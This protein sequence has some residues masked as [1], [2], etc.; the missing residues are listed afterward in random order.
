[1][2]CEQSLPA[3]LPFIQETWPASASF[4][5]PFPFILEE[6][7]AATAAS[8]CFLPT[9]YL[10][11]DRF[12]SSNMPKNMFVMNKYDKKSA[13][14]SSSTST[15]A[16]TA[17][18]SRPVPAPSAA[19]AAA[20]AT[21]TATEEALNPSSQS[22]YLLVTLQDFIRGKN[23]EKQRR[24]QQT[25][26]GANT[27]INS[28]LDASQVLLFPSS[29]SSS[30]AFYLYFLLF[31]PIFRFCFSLQVSFTDKL[32]SSLSRHPLYHTF[33]LHLLPHFYMFGSTH[34][35]RQTL[36]IILESAC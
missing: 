35:V 22:P 30:S 23:K 34:F 19:A 16:T 1:M 6:A 20:T 18:F 27:S 3:C 7:A 21:A 24:L 17:T 12:F 26:M 36:T 11:T 14:S 33:I 29:S 9:Y 2:P 5:F 4:P 15:T 13:K 28:Q 31:W 8:T 32:M 25:A 10:P